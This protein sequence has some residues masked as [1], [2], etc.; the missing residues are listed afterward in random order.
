MQNNKKPSIKILVVYHKKDK[1]Y[2]SSI[3]TPIH[4]GRALAR[5]ISKD[6][7]ISQKD[8]DWLLKN[9]IGD[10]TGDNISYLNRELNEVTA[11][12]WAWKNYDKLGNPDYIGLNHYRRF[13]YVNYGKL[14][15][16]LTKYDFIKTGFFW[17]AK[18]SVYDAWFMFPHE[19]SDDELLEQTFEISRNVLGNNMVEDYFKTG[20]ERDGYFNMFLLSRED[21]FKYCEFLFNIILKLP[22]KENQR[23]VAMI[24]ER[25]T[26]CYMSDLAKKK[27]A[28]NACVCSKPYNNLFF[29]SKYGRLFSLLRKIR[30]ILLS[31]M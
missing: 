6:G 13:Y 21:F 23:T 27:K 15:E 12:Y 11:I 16:L 2:K 30:I 22:R 7:R 18:I 4:A 31:C 17:D 10:D 20:L 1:L 24:A 19:W 5:E 25:L 8:Y 29:V 28:F 3:L 26:A 14:N 9:T